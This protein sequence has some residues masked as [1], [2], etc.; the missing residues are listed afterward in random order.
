[1]ETERKSTSRNDSKVAHGTKDGLWSLFYRST[2]VHA[3]FQSLSLILL[4]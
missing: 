3:K 4:Q 2:S 1:M